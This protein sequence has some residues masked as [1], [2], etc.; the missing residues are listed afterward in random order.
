MGQGTGPGVGLGGAPHPMKRGGPAVIHD[1][2]RNKLNPAE[3]KGTIIAFPIANPLA[4]Q[5]GRYVSPHDGANLAV[6][7]PGSKNGSITSRIAS[8]IW[9]EATLGADLIMDL[10]ENVSPCLLF[11]LVGTCKDKQVERRTLQL[12]EAFGLTVIRTGGADLGTPGTKGGDLY[13]AEEGMASGIPGF[14][15]ELEGSFKSRFAGS[16]PT[17]QIGGRGGINKFNKLVC[18]SWF[19]HCL[20]ILCEVRLQPSSPKWLTPIQNLDGSKEN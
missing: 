5:F 17:V 13:W 9:N 14:Q 10:H 1:L 6:S 11:S 19:H 15:V 12:A 7:Y 8:F 2:T 20:H 18:P 3:L 16:K 4:M